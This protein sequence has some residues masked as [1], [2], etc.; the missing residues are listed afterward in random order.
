MMASSMIMM[1]VA[2]CMAAV[3]LALTQRL[4]Q[5]LATAIEARSRDYLQRHGV[6]GVAVGAA[7]FGRSRQLTVCG[8][9]GGALLAT[10]Q[11]GDRVQT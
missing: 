8:P 9:V 3:L 2:S 6:E 5:R 11:G 1:V 7:L 4:R 10:L